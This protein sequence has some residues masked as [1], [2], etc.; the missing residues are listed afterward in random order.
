MGSVGD[1][2][3]K[4]E[5]AWILSRTKSLDSSIIK[6]LKNRLA[7]SGVRSVKLSSVLQTCEE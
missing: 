1:W 4:Q 6:R 5:Y 3:F 7:E 2:I